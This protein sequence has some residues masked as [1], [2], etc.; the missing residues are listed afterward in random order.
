MNTPS[1]QGAVVRAPAESIRV[2]AT[3]LFLVFAA[4]AEF[5]ALITIPSICVALLL[6]YFSPWVGNRGFLWIFVCL[7]LSLSLPS[8]EV[9]ASII[10][11]VWSEMHK[12]SLGRLKSWRDFF[13][14][15]IQR[16]ATLDYNV[17]QA[18]QRCLAIWTN[19]SR[20]WSGTSITSIDVIEHKIIGLAE[21]AKFEIFLEE[22]S[23]GKT[24]ARI[25][26]GSKYV[27]PLKIVTSLNAS[28]RKKFIENFVSKL[29]QDQ[30]VA[31]D[32]RKLPTIRKRRVMPAIA[33]GL[34]V[35]GPS[36]VLAQALTSDL[37]FER[38]RAIVNS[39]SCWS[40]KAKVYEHASNAV[41]AARLN[42]LS[43]TSLEKALNLRGYVSLFNLDNNYALDDFT[44][45][46]GL[47]DNERRSL[48][49]K[50][51]RTARVKLDDV[52]TR[53]IDA[54]LGL[55]TVYS[56]KNQLEKARSLLAEAIAQSKECP[57]AVDFLTLRSLHHVRG[58]LALKQGNEET[59]LNE[60]RSSFCLSA[61]NLKI[62]LLAKSSDELAQIEKESIAR[63]IKK[64]EESQKPLETR[65]DISLLTILCITLWAAL[66]RSLRM[67]LEKKDEAE[68]QRSAQDNN[69]M[70]IWKSSPELR[71]SPEAEAPTTDF[72]MVSNSM[73]GIGPRFIDTTI[74][75]AFVLDL[76]KRRAQ[77]EE[78][79]IVASTASR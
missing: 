44:E 38:E 50:Q 75:S 70:N 16:T 41:A 59:A 27:G 23:N 35:V 72:S 67:F 3:R 63:E 77:E 45:E 42:P 49:S 22:M 54:K 28:G 78:A 79:Y 33:A 69:E 10:A 2:A 12:G 19:L 9:A 64:F 60:L 18:F 5:T 47:L 21:G 1:P 6:E 66:C 71:I 15:S 52:A 57:T 55:A 46:L 13:P 37:L 39:M 8:L 56:N 73:S 29:E 14:W 65:I 17:D 25:S 53:E 61:M 74:Q 11:T 48:E 20:A 43:K 24:E 40:Q 68:V 58:I 4:L 34:I 76:S 51:D 62:N 31:I 32:P 26:I 30:A 36:I 7:M